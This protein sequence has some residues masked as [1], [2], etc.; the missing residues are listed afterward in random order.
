MLDIWQENILYV[1][2][3][4]LWLS[5]PTLI[6]LCIIEFQRKLHFAEEKGRILVQLAFNLLNELLWCKIGYSF[7]K[8]CILGVIIWKLWALFFLTFQFTLHFKIEILRSAD[9]KTIGNKH[10]GSI[11][12]QLQLIKYLLNL[13]RIQSHSALTFDKPLRYM[14]NFRTLFVAMHNLIENSY[15][16]LGSIKRLAI[17]IP[18]VCF[19]S[20][21]K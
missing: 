20:I 2:T 16:A 7:T 17:K 10:S 18:P 15:F 9:L 3:F 8:I 19:K 1:S 4:L 6:S 5:F 14:S 11:F 13:K 21:K 12:V